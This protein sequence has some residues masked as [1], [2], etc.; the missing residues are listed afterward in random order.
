MKT[1]RTNASA[2]GGGG[3][4]EPAFN[5]ELAAV[6]TT[7]PLLLMRSTEI[8][9]TTN[10]DSSS[11]F[12][13][14]LEAPVE[15][16]VNEYALVVTVGSTAPAIGAIV[17]PLGTVWLPSLTF[18]PLKTYIILFKQVKRMSGMGFDIFAL[19]FSN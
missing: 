14:T 5:F 12:T 10:L 6:P 3:T 18:E 19:H 2:G 13:I 17:F 1:G 11:A 16:K 7:E 4:P 8:R 9:L 15:D